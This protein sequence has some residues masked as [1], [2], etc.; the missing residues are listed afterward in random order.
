MAISKL[1]C[2]SV[3][4][5]SGSGIYISPFISLI[6]IITVL[7]SVFFTQSNNRFIL[8]EREAPKAE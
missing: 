8:S 2:I 1:G 7:T 5:S 3:K 4:L 6:S